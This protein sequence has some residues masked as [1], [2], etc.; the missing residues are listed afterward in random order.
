MK[1]CNYD[2]TVKDNEERTLLHLAAISGD[3]VSNLSN[4]KFFK[5]NFRDNFKFKT[6]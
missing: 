2:Y 5:A 4:I 3:E 6:N 1:Y